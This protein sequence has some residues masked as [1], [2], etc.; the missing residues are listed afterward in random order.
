MALDIGGAPS[1]EKLQKR[2]D[3]PHTR[4]GRDGASD[5][6]QKKT[7]LSTRAR[8]RP[9][10]KDGRPESAP[11]CARAAAPE[12]RTMRKT[13]P[14]GMRAGNIIRWLDHAGGMQAAAHGIRRRMA[15]EQFGAHA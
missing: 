4:I 9:K 7:P 5:D 8:F 12:A 6:G 2:K 10:A 11:T 15:Q 14:A 3:A 1:K 13:Q